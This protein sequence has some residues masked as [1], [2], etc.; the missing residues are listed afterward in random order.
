MF[1]LGFDMYIIRTCCQEE[2]ALPGG[3]EAGKRARMREG[4]HGP[5]S[6]LMGE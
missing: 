4:S 6:I 1:F 5:L 3:G 2:R